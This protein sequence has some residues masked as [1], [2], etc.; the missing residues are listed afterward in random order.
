MSQEVPQQLGLLRVWIL[1]GG[2]MVVVGVER[3]GRIQE[4]WRGKSTQRKSRYLRRAKERQSQRQLQVFS[5]DRLKEWLVVPLTKLKV[6]EKQNKFGEWDGIE[7]W[8]LI[9]N[10]IGLCSWE[11]DANP[12]TI[13][14]DKEY[15]FYANKM[16]QGRPLDTFSVRAGPRK[17]NQGDER[18]ATLS[19]LAWHL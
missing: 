2:G 5:C 10:L 18:V 16:A 6:Q 8:C 15:H 13:P 11:G 9:K 19:Y 14:S 12:W 1:N 4:T 3:R 17:T 7:Q